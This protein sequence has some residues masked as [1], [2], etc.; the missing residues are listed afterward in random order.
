MHPGEGNA[1]ENGTNNHGLDGPLRMAVLA[2]RG[3]LGVIDL[4]ACPVPGCAERGQKK[5]AKKDL[6]KEGRK[7]YTEGKKQPCLS[8][9][10][11]ELFDG[12]GGWAGHQH[13]VGQGKHEAS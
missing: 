3:R 5:T 7:G 10:L 8:G 11:E 6:F 9:G 13:T 12:C 2:E 1:G 4:L